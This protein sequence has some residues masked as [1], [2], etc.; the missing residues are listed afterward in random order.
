MSLLTPSFRRPRARFHIPYQCKRRVV[1]IWAK[2]ANFAVK[3]LQIQ[4]IF[5]E[6]ITENFDFLTAPPM[7]EPSLQRQSEGFPQSVSRRNQHP[8]LPVPVL[9]G[10]IAKK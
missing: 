4:N 3:Q 2:V 8:V 1:K 5:P 10:L 9:K 7:P 6:I